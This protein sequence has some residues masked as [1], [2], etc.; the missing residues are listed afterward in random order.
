MPGGS[1]EMRRVTPV[2]VQWRGVDRDK[3][4]VLVTQAV[5]DHLASEIE[6]LHHSR[7]PKVFVESCCNQGRDVEPGSSAQTGSRSFTGLLK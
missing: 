2:T 7:L 3:L 5:V 4:I 6:T 1:V